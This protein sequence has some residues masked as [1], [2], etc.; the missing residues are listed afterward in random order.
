M[1]RIR[2]PFLLRS[3]CLSGLE[4]DARRA[5]GFAE[6]DQL[7]CVTLRQN[8]RNFLAEFG[9]GSQVVDGLEQAIHA[10][11][12]KSQYVVERLALRI[13]EGHESRCREI[14]ASDAAVGARG[15]PSRTTV[16][17]WRKVIFVEP[18]LADEIGLHDFQPFGLSD[19]F[20]VERDGFVNKFL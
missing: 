11:P 9:N 7:V 1:K 16:V 5:F 20:S 10:F 8:L 15:G 2:S 12:G 19:D 4:A 18:S 3:L 17:R 14:D 13:D 6:F